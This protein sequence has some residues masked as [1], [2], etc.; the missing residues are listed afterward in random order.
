[1][2]ILLMHPDPSK[3]LVKAA[4][5]HDI[6][7]VHTGDIPSFV[8][9]NEFRTMEH[10]VSETI[11][12]LVDL[13]EEDSDWLSAADHLELLLWC[14]DQTGLGNAQVLRIHG[15]LTKWFM[16]NEAWIP[17]PIIEAAGNYNSKRT[18]PI[19]ADE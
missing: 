8:K 1:M 15:N 10:Q 6:H 9:N 7:E 16:D 17:E 3:A 2:I 14:R 13:N 12:T 5:L 4:L 11:G 18:L 19:G